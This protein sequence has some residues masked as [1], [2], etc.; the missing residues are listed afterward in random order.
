VKVW[1]VGAIAVAS[2]VAL[3]ALATNVHRDRLYA[4]AG[5]D[6]LRTMAALDVAFPHPDGPIA[7]G[8]HPLFTENIGGL[9]DE[10]NV[11]GALQ[12]HRRHEGVLGYV[13]KNRAAWLRAPAHLRFDQVASLRSEFEL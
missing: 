13:A 3:G 2:V 6:V 7:L 5:D 11:D 4:R 9:L 1:R 12:V 8:P 10:S